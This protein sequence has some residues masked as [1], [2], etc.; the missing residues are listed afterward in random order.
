MT[1]L[2]WDDLLDAE[3]VGELCIPTTPSV[4]S[5]DITAEMLRDLT[6]DAPKDAPANYFILSRDS[7]GRFDVVQRFVDFYIDA[8]GYPARS[9]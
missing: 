2:A 9:F 3:D 4:V 7:D 8:D 1:G 6:N 5:I